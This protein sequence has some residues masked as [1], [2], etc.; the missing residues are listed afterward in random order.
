MMSTVTQPWKKNTWTNN[1]GKD[2][3]V[4]LSTRLEE[5]PQRAVISFVISIVSLAK[6]I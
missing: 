5:T 2:P 4:Q 1:P 6:Q 3:C